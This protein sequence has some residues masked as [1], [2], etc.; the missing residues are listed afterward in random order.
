MA[1]TKKTKIKVA[2]KSV[3]KKPVKKQVVAKKAAPPK[4]PAPPAA[5]PKPQG[6]S[7]YLLCGGGEVTLW[8]RD[9][10]SFD[11][12]VAQAKSAP[13]DSG[14]RRSPPPRTQVLG[15]NRAWSYR[16]VQKMK[17]THAE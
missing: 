4:A 13:A 11:A 15:A 17:A 10:A 8:F 7:L 14:G 2:K 6:G 1:T 12:A 9:D 3:V 5:P 16:T